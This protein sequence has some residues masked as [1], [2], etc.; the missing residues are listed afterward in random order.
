MKRALPFSTFPQTP[1]ISPVPVSSL[2]I[3]YNVLSLSHFIGADMTVKVWDAHQ[4]HCLH[5]FT[6]HERGINDVKWSPDSQFLLSASDDTTL[7]LHSP[8]VTG[9]VHQLSLQVSLIILLFLRTPH[10]HSP[11]I[12]ATSSASAGD[13]RE[14]WPPV[15]PL[16]RVCVSGTYER[17]SVYAPLRPMRIP[18]PASPSIPMAVF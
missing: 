1:A 13:R 5:S 6:G 11:A 2:T 3:G 18:S 12:W 17:A 16:T 15:V 4:G 10:K 7:R 9:K 8:F 14:G